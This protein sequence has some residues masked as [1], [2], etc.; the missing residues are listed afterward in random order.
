MKGAKKSGVFNVM[1]GKPIPYGATVIAKKTVNFSI[2]SLYAKSCELVL[3]NKKQKKPFAVIAF[4]DEYKIGSVF[5]M[6]VNGL[7]YEN[8]EYGF[9]MDGSFNPRE[10]HWFDPTKVLLDPYAKAIRGRDVWGEE[11][12]WGSPYQYRA[13]IIK[14][15][16]FDW[17]EDYP[18][19]IPMK[20][21]IIYEMHVRGFTR[22]ESSGVKNKGTFAGVVEKIPYLKNLGINC[23]EL[24]PIFEFDEFLKMR[25]NYSAEAKERLKDYWG[26]DPI[27]Y[28]A[29][30]AG[31]S[32]SNDE[33]SN[34]VNELKDMVRNFHKNGI[35]VI[36][37]VVFNHTGESDENG[38]C[39]SFRGIDNKTYYMLDK[40]GNYKN[41]TGCHNTVNCNNPVVREFILDCLRYWV[42]EYHIDG[43]RF[44]LASVMVRDEHGEPMN[45][46]PIIEAI[47][48]DP[49]LRK[50]KLI[51]EA[52][53]ATGLY[54]VGTFPSYR[55][56]SDWNGKFRDDLR[57]FLKGDSGMVGKM[58]YRIQGSPDIFGDRGASA[59]INFITA[60]DGFTLMD[61][62]SYSSKH[63]EENREENSDGTNENYSWNWGCE[64]ATTDVGI[65]SLRRKLIKN[66]A[67][68]LMLSQGV[69]MI[70]VGDELGRSQGGNNNAY[71]QDNEISWIDWD[72]LKSND[73]I[74]NYF[75]KIIEF[76][77]A[78]PILRSKH[79][80]ENKVR[81]GSKYPDISFHGIKAW[82]F[83]DS[84][85]S[86]IFA[87]MF[88]GQHIKDSIIYIAMNMHWETQ[89][90]T[91]PKLSG[92]EWH[93][94]ANTGKR[95]PDDIY[96]VGEECLLSNQSKIDI[97]PRSIVILVGK[98][99]LGL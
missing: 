63:N 56:W 84:Y 80:F 37:D 36:L 97:E 38:P 1:P 99:L 21:L 25:G 96:G 45:N 86:R 83:D 41:Y 49:I 28:F 75:K 98:N 7:D 9:K 79:R 14:N 20:D 6:T 5:T 3:F 57:K 61:L 92:I 60:H 52:W 85:D 8:I 59:S 55:R 95:A 82:Q 90:F 88:N 67:S 13:Q 73:E 4:P 78:H 51:A 30:K 40:E 23:V 16:D 76:R 53:D 18:L 10:G 2:F 69:P 89:E 27:A 17:E 19:H 68:I 24:L 87:V 15:D 12:D 81:A 44:D 91:L 43:F 74:Y 70:L 65:N 29:P 77:K 46:P 33:G 48:Y 72:L 35:E 62:V 58:I 47:S 31:Y 22:H 66:A 54:Q 93:E 11:P 32:V 39:I 64:G 94:F 42:T 50:C 26:Y 34:P 71:C